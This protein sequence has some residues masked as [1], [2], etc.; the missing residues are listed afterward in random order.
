MPKRMVNSA[1]MR[2]ITFQCDFRKLGS[3]CLPIVKL[4]GIYKS[5]PICLVKFDSED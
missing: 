4:N 1:I 3:L 2:V 5:N